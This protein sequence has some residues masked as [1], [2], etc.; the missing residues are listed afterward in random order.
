MNSRVIDAVQLCIQLFRLQVEYLFTTMITLNFQ[1]FTRDSITR[2]VSLLRS[3]VQCRLST[4]IKF[5]AYMDPKLLVKH[6]VSFE[7]LLVVLV[8]HASRVCILT[9]LFLRNEFL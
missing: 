7:M 1:L 9:C 4:R 5:L 6:I 8:I 2:T 3:F